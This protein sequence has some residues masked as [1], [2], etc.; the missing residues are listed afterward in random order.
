MLRLYLAGADINFILR[1]VDPSWSYD[2]G[3]LTGRI[4]LP[5]GAITLVAVPS[6]VEDFLVLSLP[7]D[8]I[9]GDI[10]R[11]LFGTVAKML[12]GTLQEQIYKRAR[13]MLA[14]IGLPM[15]TV[16]VE[17]VGG[18]GQIRVSLYR[19]N[20]WLARTYRFKSLKLFVQ[21]LSFFE[22]GAEVTVG[23]FR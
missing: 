21:Q 2:Y 3:C 4:K 19:L 12:W 14:R 5:I 20:E 6:V 13:V 8:R 16:E 15:D 23:L 1:Q 7:L 17:K 22:S 9:K 11:G 10:T 18:N